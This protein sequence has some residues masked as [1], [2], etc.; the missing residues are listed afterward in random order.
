[1]YSLTKH[2]VEAAVSQGA[3][4]G[5]QHYYGIRGNTYLVHVPIFY[6]HNEME[7]VDNIYHFESFCHTQAGALEYLKEKKNNSI[8]DYS[9]LCS[10]A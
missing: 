4:A 2:N 6:S 3:P 5:L 10:V 1:M 7:E 9:L 8:K